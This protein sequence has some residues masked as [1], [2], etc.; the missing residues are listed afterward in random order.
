MIV[1][2][3]TMTGISLSVDLKKKCETAQLLCKFADEVALLMDF[4]LTSTGDILRHIGQ[5]E[6]FSSLQFVKSYD[7]EKKTPVKT[8]LDKTDDRELASFL[9]ELGTTDIENQLRLV[10]AYKAFAESRKNHFQKEYE[11]RRKLY[12]AFGV[13]GGL[14]LA[15]MLA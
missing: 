1:I 2:F 6:R 10:K 14:V 12:T 11:K 15:L 4:K 13:S 9:A 5:D 7:M 3:S 8:N